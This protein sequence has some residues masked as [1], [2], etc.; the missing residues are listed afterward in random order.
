MTFRP[1][2]EFNLAT[3]LLGAR[4]DAG[5]GERVA[6]VTD[7]AALTYRD[8]DHL[9]NRFANLLREMGIRPEE[10]VVVAL[11]DGPAFVGAL[12]G[13]LKVGAVVVM[14]NPEL[15]PD[16]ISYFYRYTR[17]RYAFCEV[18]RA[19]P[20]RRAA[21][22][23]PLLEQ[24]CLVGTADVDEALASAS[25]ASPVFD[26]HRDDPAI[27][28]FSGG[29][30]GR[31]KAVIQTHRSF[32]NTTELYGKRT[33]GYTA[34]DVTISAPKLFFGYATGSNLFFPF[35]VGAKTVLFP[36]RCTAERLFDAIERHRP[37]ILVAVPTMIRNLISHESAASRDLSSLRIATSAG[38][39][40]PPELHARWNEAFGVDLL[41]G[42]GTAEMWHI[43]ISNR[44]GHVTPGTLGRAV[45]GFEVQV[46]DDDGRPV[47][48]GETGWLRVKGESR[49]LGYWHQLEKTC[50]GFQGHWY[51]T[52]DMVTR[53]ADG[54]F[55]YAGRGDDMLK[56]SGKWLATREVEECLA[57]HPS[58]KEA[59]VIGVVDADG[60]TK[61]H[62]F[63]VPHAHDD[64]LSDTL[65]EYVRSRLESYKYPREIVFLDD[66]PRT[67]L[68]KVDRGK[69]RG[70]SP[71]R[72]S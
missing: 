68:G 23:A 58:V 16:A 36:E 56:V 50:D 22:S 15:K 46:C 6:I 57:T 5:D 60:L 17:A 39:A 53:N 63:V 43:F 25:A 62:A 61:P 34:D 21:R 38:E 72:A 48:D 10:R 31:P 24:V 20:W 67:H 1:P 30:T 41:D 42:L 13:I 19:D 37:T 28:L 4:L 40:L 26:T 2:E 70:S 69:L 51:V 27:W 11:E 47:A 55:T 12:F 29:T 49:G 65:K 14:L 18:S 52:G 32:A 64:T 71:R 35:S 7:E 54:T 44:P 3:Y 9:S 66:L 45:D 33:I 8:V 59:A